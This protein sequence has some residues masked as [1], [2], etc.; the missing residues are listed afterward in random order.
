[1]VEWTCLRVR[2]MKHIESQHKR[3]YRL[4]AAQTHM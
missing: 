4:A 3:Q 1:M 2:N